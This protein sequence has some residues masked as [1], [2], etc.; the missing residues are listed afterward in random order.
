[1]SAGQGRAGCAHALQPRP[2]TSL[3]TPMLNVGSSC[4]PLPI[5][6]AMP[7]T[8]PRRT[9]VALPGAGVA[10]AAANTTM[11]DPSSPPYDYAEALAKS[12]IY[13][14]SQVR[15]GT[16][17]QPLSLLRSHRMCYR[18]LNA[19]ER[20]NCSWRGSL[21]EGGAVDT[22]Y[23]RGNALSACYFVFSLLPSKPRYHVYNPLLGR[24]RA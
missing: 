4:W 19:N 8:T 14:D 3:H 9:P 16:R 24:S 2:T 20:A 22:A 21:A 1:M 7:P 10:A 12:L 15:G 13:Y 5:S 6:A 11:P 23:G 17:G 18:S